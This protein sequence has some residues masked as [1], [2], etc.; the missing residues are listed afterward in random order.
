M[1][2]I[3]GK[4]EREKGMVVVKIKKLEQKKEIIKNRRI[5]VEKGI[6]IEDNLTRKE[7]KMKRQLEELGRQ[8]RMRGRRV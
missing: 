4:K 5:V 2:E 7:R 6:R 8:E 1:R 3:G